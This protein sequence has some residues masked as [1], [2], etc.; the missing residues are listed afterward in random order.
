M[1]LQSSKKYL[2]SFIP[3]RWIR[4]MGRWTV[5]ITFHWSAVSF[6]RAAVPQFR[7]AGLIHDGS[8]V[9]VMSSHTAS[10]MSLPST[11][12]VS[13]PGPGFLGR[14]IFDSLFRVTLASPPISEG[15]NVP[16]RLAVRPWLLWSPYH[17]DSSNNTYSAKSPPSSARELIYRS[18]I[19]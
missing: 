2:P 7:G 5:A 10:R 11:S 16:I 14:G 9:R 15:W 17:Q 19:R 12:L 1:K 13:V 4:V 3:Q 6:P 8:S 18:C